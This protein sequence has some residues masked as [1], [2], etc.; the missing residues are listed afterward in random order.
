MFIPRHVV[1]N[2]CSFYEVSC[3]HV[4]IEWIKLSG[5]CTSQIETPTHIQGVRVIFSCKH[6]PLLKCHSLPEGWCFSLKCPEP[7]RR[8][9]I[10]L[11]SLS[12]GRSWGHRRRE[13]WA[14]Y[15]S[16]TAFVARKAKFKQWMVCG[17]TRVTDVLSVFTFAIWNVFTHRISNFRK[18][19]VA[20]EDS[21][22]FFAPL[23]Y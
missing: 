5:L 3:N 1:V 8:H 19:F 13:G 11:Q 21:Y 18:V 7:H 20:E 22:I 17:I 9:Y 10:S 23:S 6:K 12:S 2:C 15:G 14:W 4:I 16:S